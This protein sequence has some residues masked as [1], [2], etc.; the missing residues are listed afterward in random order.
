MK[1]NIWIF[2]LISGA[3]IT[4]IA[5]YMAWVC[6]ANPEFETNDFLGYTA[7]LVIFSLIFIGI[8][9][10]RNHYLGGQITFGQAFK[11][12]FFMS[13][14]AGTLYVLVWLVDY[15]VFIPQYVDQYTLHVLHKAKT[16]GATATELAETA[17]SMA[18]FKEMYKNPLFVIVTTFLEVFPIALIV[19]LISALILKRKQK[20]PE[21]VT[22]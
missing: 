6:C 13:L 16:N 10:Y 5:N 3:L 15:Y 8:R 7:M 20:D 1:K 11:A 17:K 2:G 19:S 14:I 12:G 22:A 18:E 4:A 9:N 21:G